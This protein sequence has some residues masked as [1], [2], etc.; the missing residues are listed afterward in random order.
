MKLKDFTKMLLALESQGS[1]A[2]CKVVAL[3]GYNDQ[4]PFDIREAFLGNYNGETV[5]FL[6]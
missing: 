5:V 3:N 1:N 6:N 4:D 2:S